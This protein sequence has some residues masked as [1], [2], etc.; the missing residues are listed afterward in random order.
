VI[1]R[2]KLNIQKRL[3][4]AATWAHFDPAPLAA[5]SI[6]IQAAMESGDPRELDQ[7]LRTVCPS[8]MWHWPE[9][10]EH[11]KHQE[12]KPTRLRMV[13]AVANRLMRDDYWAMR[14]PQLMELTDRHPFWQFRPAGDRADPP[15]CAEHAGRLERFN[16]AFWKAHNPAACSLINCRCTIRLIMDHELNDALRSLY[17]DGYVV[18]P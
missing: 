5:R 17:L 2:W 7:L 1:D 12:T 3:C 14:I 4:I 13:A 18:S 16:S 6:A 10:F 11:A 9:Y 15:P 8:E